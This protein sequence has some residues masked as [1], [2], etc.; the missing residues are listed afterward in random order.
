MIVVGRSSAE[1]RE[2]GF[3]GSIWCDPGR[4]V[5]RMFGA[6]KPTADTPVVVLVNPNL[7]SY[8]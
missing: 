7:R 8:V 2:A 5:C 3:Y 6:D 4:A 1:V